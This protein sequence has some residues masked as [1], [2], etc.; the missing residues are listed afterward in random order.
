MKILRQLIKPEVRHSR[1]S[2]IDTRKRMIFSL[3]F[4]LP[5]ILLFS[6]MENRSEKTVHSKKNTMS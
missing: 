3:L 2:S 4:Q 5:K 6:A 1:T